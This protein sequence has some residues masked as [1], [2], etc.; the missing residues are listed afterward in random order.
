LPESASASLR[1]KKAPLRRG[2]AAQKALREKKGMSDHREKGDCKAP[3]VLRVQKEIKAIQAPRVCEARKGK[4]DCKAHRVQ[5][6]IK[7]TRVPAV[8]PVR[9]AFRARKATRVH[10][11]LQEPG[12]QSIK[13]QN[14]LDSNSL[15]WYSRAG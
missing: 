11:R 13:P 10:R 15:G 3:R 4:E 14:R 7:A 1:W 8:C 9:R 5:R 6:E 12:S 2:R